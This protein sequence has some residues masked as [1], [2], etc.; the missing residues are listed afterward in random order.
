MP[1]ITRAA[2]I[3]VCQQGSLFLSGSQTAR[4]SKSLEDPMIH[5]SVLLIS[6]NKDTLMNG[7]TQEVT[8]D[9]KR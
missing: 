3:Q 4:L 6:F 7:H 9:A 8:Q 1:N 5:G 2:I